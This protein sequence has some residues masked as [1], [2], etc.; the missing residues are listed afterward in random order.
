MFT[1]IC[2]N[3]LLTA[4]KIENILRHFFF[5]NLVPLGKRICCTVVR[6]QLLRDAKMR[7]RLRNNA[8]KIDVKQEAKSNVNVNICPYFKGRKKKYLLK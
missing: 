1:Q 3:Y 7:C 2:T 4:H 8:V 6:R 5:L